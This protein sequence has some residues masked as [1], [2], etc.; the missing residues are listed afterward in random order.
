MAIDPN[1][2]FIQVAYGGYLLVSP[3]ATVKESLVYAEPGF[4]AI[5]PIEFAL[6]KSD[7]VYFIIRKR[8][9]SDTDG[10]TFDDLSVNNF[11]ITATD[12]TIGALLTIDASNF[13]SSSLYYDSQWEDGL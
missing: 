2:T 12:S 1:G 4:T 8:S 13:S 6:D 3:P 5:S 11:T 9:A 7:Q 10:T